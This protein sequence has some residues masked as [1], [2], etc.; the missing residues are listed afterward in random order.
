MSIEKAAKIVDKRGKVNVRQITI[1][2]GFAS[3]WP[4]KRHLWVDWLEHIA[5][6]L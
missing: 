3:D 4:K 2:F 1:G 5:R 6:V